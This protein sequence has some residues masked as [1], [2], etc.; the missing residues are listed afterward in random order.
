MIQI[1]NLQ[2]ENTALHKSVDELTENMRA[3]EQFEV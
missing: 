2:E 3:N 1:E